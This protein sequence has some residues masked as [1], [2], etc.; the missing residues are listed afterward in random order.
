MDTKEKV[1]NILQDLTGNDVSEDMDS[2]L[3][4]AGLLDSMGTVQLLLQLQSELGVNVPVSEF[5][6]SKWDTPNKIIAQVKELQA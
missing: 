4:D 6:R 2:N 3:F 5:E 1:L